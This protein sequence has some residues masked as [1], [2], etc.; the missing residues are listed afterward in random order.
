MAV[1]S[2]GARTEVSEQ[3]CLDLFLLK[4]SANA[5]AFLLFECYRKIFHQWQEAQQNLP[6]RP[7]QLSPDIDVLQVT[8]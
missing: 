6:V 7:Q 4:L 5:N 1:W 2:I 8:Q 3:L